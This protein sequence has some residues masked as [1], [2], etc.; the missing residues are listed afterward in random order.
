MRDLAV[1]ITMSASC[2]YKVKKIQTRTAIGFQQKIRLIQLS[3]Y[4][5]IAN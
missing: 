4:L 3:L 1:V 5:A 2:D